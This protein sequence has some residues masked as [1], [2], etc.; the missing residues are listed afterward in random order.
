VAGNAW[1]RGEDAANSLRYELELGAGVVDLRDVMRRLRLVFIARDFGPD[2]GDGRYV[3]TGDQAAVVINTSVE[4]RGRMRFTIAHEIGHHKMHADR[5]GVVFIDDQIGFGGEK[6]E[7]EVEA[8]AFAAYFLA[9]TKVLRA[10]LDGVKE[11]TFDTII[12]LMGRYGLSFRATVWRLKNSGIISL[13]QANGLIEESEGRVNAA[14][15]AK[16]IYDEEAK[17]FEGAS[18]PDEL[19]KNALKLYAHSVIDEARLAEMLRVSVEDARALI[20][21]ENI[22]PDPLELDDSDL[23]DLF[24]DEDEQDS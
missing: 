18:L 8:D 20:T 7:H 2:G 16:G 19:E 12:E 3:K 15:A 11:I 1:Q 9:P 21:K 24:D 6:E 5:E 17:L 10:D 22:T 14:V 23:E 4:H 13:K